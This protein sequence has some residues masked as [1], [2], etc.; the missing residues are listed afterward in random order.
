MLSLTACEWARKPL[1]ET[2]TIEVPGP[3]HVVPLD[4]SLTAPTYGP[5]VPHR[6]LFCDD[7]ERLLDGYMRALDSAN[8]DKKA[9]R[10]IEAKAGAKD[11]AKP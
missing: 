3:A 8:A 1:V 4:A 7:F 5:D 9:I 6:P 11:S 2:R 10:A